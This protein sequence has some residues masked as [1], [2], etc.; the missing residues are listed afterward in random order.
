MTENTKAVLLDLDDTL[1]FP[2]DIIDYTQ[3]EDDTS[4]HKPDPKVFEPAIAWLASRHISPHETL[5]VGDGLHDMQAAIGAGF[6]FVGVTKGLVTADEFA[7]AGVTSI[8]NLDALLLSMGI[9][10]KH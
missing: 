2:K 10:A 1:G 7:E 5:Y 3:T 9:V 4:F 8:Q 6:N